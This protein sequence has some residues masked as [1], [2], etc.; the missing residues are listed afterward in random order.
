MHF[1]PR[2]PCGERRRDLLCLGHVHR[3][4]IHALLA[5][6]D[7]WDRFHV[8]LY[9]NFNPRSP[10]G[11]RP[12]FSIPDVQRSRISIHAL[13]AESDHKLRRKMHRTQRFQS[14]LSLRRA[15]LCLASAAWVPAY[16]N[17]RSPCGER[18]PPGPL[19]GPAPLRFQSTLS[20]RRATVFRPPPP[21]G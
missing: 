2:S 21:G 13:L 17:P 1:N 11:E 12:G 7:L 19:T 10:C 15:T 3:I 4:S 5:E 20:L 8:F 14:T 18:R 9:R 16:F 6:S